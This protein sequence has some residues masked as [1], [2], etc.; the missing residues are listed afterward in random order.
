LDNGYSVADHTLSRESPVEIAELPF[1]FSKLMLLGV[2]RDGAFRS[3]PFAVSEQILPGDVLTC[4]GSDALHD[5]FE[6]AL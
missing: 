3:G 2:H 4:Y 1:V 5:E 6:D